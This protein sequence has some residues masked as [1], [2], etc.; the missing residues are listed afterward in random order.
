MLYLANM[1]DELISERGLRLLEERFGDVRGNWLRGARKARWD[2]LSPTH[3]LV[4]PSVLPESMTPSSADLRSLPC[5][6]WTLYPDQMLGWNLQANCYRFEIPPA[7]KA[8]LDSVPVV[9]ANSGF[10]AALFA[11]IGDYALRVCHLGI[12][13]TT[14]QRAQPRRR[15]PQPLAVVWNHMWRTQKNFH[16]AL[17]IMLFLAR[18]FPNV[19][20][21]IGRQDSWAD[22]DHSPDWL[23]DAYARFQATVRTT[24][25][26][27]IGMLPHQPSQAAYWQ[28]LASMDI[29]FSCSYEESFGVAML[30][31]ACAGLACV[32]PNRGAYAELHSHALV[33]APDDAAVAAGVERLILDA[34]L[35]ATIAEAGQK[36]ARRLDVRVAVE[37]LTD[38][39]VSQA[40]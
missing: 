21:F 14:I 12:D 36:Q 19:R 8:V 1:W 6:A 9:A 7:I 22:H 16:G 31:A 25:L 5:V 4:A 23:R 13:A 38:L 24:G 3:L 2:D 39:L 33:T 32:V 34:H 35:R 27:N 18:R 11:G 15:E 40:A 30:E 20:F 37:T 28:G 26:H 17:E 29:A 10:T